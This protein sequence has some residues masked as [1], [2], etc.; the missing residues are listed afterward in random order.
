MGQP[1]KA[2]NPQSRKQFDRAIDNALL[3]GNLTAAHTLAKDAVSRG[4]F[5]SAWQRPSR[6]FVPD[7]HSTFF[8]VADATT[9]YIAELEAPGV[10]Q[11]IQEEVKAFNQFFAASSFGER[12][13]AFR[14]TVTGTKTGLHY[15]SQSDTQTEIEPASWGQV[16]LMDRRLNFTKD[17]R[18]YFP[19]TVEVLEAAVRRSSDQI[20]HMPPGGIV[21]ARLPP[22]VSIRAHVGL[23]NA[24]LRVSYGVFVPKTS[25]H[26]VG[27]QPAVG[28]RVGNETRT[29]R[30]GK[31]LILDDSYEHSAWNNGDTDRIVLLA[32]FWHPG[33]SRSQRRALEAGKF[34]YET[35]ES[36]KT[37]LFQGNAWE[38]IRCQSSAKMWEKM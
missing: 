18:K 27:Q 4:F 38:K 17:A 32:D 30:E 15:D 35:L 28:I 29:W 10:L 14:N 20:A 5:P 16:L 23:T 9:P 19:R 3:S 26:G 36:G 6:A 12:T 7:V 37:N 31:A 2:Q 25:G 21:L 1:C 11:T 34:F 33:M 24:R 13:D 8:P 22:H